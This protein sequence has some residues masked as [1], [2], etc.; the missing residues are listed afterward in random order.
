MRAALGLVTVLRSGSRAVLA[1]LEWMRGCHI[2]VGS[3][4]SM[5]P[6]AM[7]PT[8]TWPRY[9]RPHP[10]DHDRTAPPRPARRQAPGSV[11]GGTG[12]R[13]SRREVGSRWRRP[14]GRSDSTGYTPV[15]LPAG[16]RPHA[17]PMRKGSS[18]WP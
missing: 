3:P 1:V 14:L 15:A 8:S 13:P 10:T 16:S 18:R 12:S 2:T 7:V 4:P 5:V 6:R 9:R 11:R 17:P